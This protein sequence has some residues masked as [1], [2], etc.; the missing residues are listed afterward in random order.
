ML[1]LLASVWALVTGLACIGTDAL[2]QHA[3]L[4]T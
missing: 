1:V 2:V 4:R 3:Q